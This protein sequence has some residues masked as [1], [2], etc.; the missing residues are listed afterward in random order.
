METV[1]LSS[2]STLLPTGEWHVD[3]THSRVG[4]AVRKLGA[5]SVRG[6]FPAFAGMIAIDAV[7]LAASGV[8]SVGGLDTGSED[9]DAHLRDLFGAEAFGQIM[10]RDGR[11]SAVDEHTW[12]VTG[13]LTIRD[14][15]CA[16]ELT[17]SGTVGTR[18]KLHG[19]IDRR[20]FGLTWNRAIEASGVVSTTVR[21]E[22]DLEFVRV[23][24]ADQHIHR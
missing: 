20:D 4:F 24:P 10:F 14:R 17:A 13:D 6:H 8:V 23:P 18:L 3:A 9:R 22:L 5:G 11:M 1:S 19:E 12:R 21:I 2:P 15:S 7:G 16:V